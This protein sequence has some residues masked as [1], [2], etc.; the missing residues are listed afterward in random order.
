MTTDQA[1]A[2]GRA[3]G[4][5]SLIEHLTELR[6]RIVKSLAAIV[7]GAIVVWIFYLSLIHI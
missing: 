4:D 3:D 5:M 7:V 2:Q 1:P 6:T